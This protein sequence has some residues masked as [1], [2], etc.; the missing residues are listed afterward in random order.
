[1]ADAP[2]SGFTFDESVPLARDELD[3]VARWKG[4]D[5]V[6]AWSGRPVRLQFRLRAMRVY[7]FQ[8]VS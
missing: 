7:A 8:F 6:G 4:Q 1:M 2:L 3:G 5:E